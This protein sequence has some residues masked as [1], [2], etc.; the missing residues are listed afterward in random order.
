[1]FWLPLWM[2]NSSPRLL[3]AQVKD[4]KT[5]LCVECQ[6]FVTVKMTAFVFISYFSVML[7]TMKD[8]LTSK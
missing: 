6:G 1:M 4:C 3:S 7:N 2:N 5:V 8:T